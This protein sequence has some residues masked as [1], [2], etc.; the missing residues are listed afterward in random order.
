MT[1]VSLIYVH[2]CCKAYV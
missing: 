1:E 2:T